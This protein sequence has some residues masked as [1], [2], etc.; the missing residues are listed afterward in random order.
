ML[1]I[2]PYICIPIYEI[3]VCSAL[4]LNIAKAIL[5]RKLAH[6]GFIY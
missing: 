5:K 2:L 3:F 1:N 6:R 4:F